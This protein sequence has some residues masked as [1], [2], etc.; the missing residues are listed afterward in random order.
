MTAQLSCDICVIGGGSAGLS[1]AAGAAQ[2]GADTILIERGDMGGDCLNS[3]CVPS[4]SLL[5]AAKAAHAGAQAKDFGITYAA[6]RIDFPAVQAHVQDVIDSIAPHDSVERF[7]GLGVRVL[8][9]SAQFLSPQKLA[10]GDQRIH[11]RRFVLATGSRPLIPPVP[12]LEDVPYLTNETVFEVQDCPEHLII[13]GGGPI[14][15]ELGQAF[16]RLGA[17]VSIVEMNRMLGREDRGAAQL[18]RE[19][20][21]AEGIAIHE[22]TSI[23]EVRHDTAGLQVVLKNEEGETTLEGARLL[24]AAGRQPVT[25]GL[26]LEAAKVVHDRRGIQ[27]DARLRTS[28]RRIFA[29]GDVIGGP[30]FTHAAG[31]QAGIILRNA[32][33]RLPAKADYRALPRVTYTAPELAQVGLTEA[34]AREQGG[35]FEVLQHSLAENDRARCERES[36]GFIK[37]LATPSGRILGATIL[38]AHAGELILPWTL[39]IAR[40]MKLSAL[41]GII[42]PYP[43]LSEVSKQVA[44]HYYTPKLFSSRT[45]RLVRLFLRLG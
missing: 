24:V 38:S 40:N 14:G 2:M 3:G 22:N 12:G 13:L 28:N 18:L 1:V 15:C 45:R 37:I 35:K 27:V 33:F 8:R 36:E 21:Q 30:Q 29:A 20:L 17:R 31:Y 4:K 42:A 44:A 9:E 6:P 5:A 19:R 7:E 16:R 11:A 26:N 41:A 23:S 32:L 25:D 34:E 43:T 39:A 10:V